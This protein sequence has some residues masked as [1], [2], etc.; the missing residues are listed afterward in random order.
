ML[1]I[2]LYLLLQLCCLCHSKDQAN[3]VRSFLTD[4]VVFYLNGSE[5]FVAVGV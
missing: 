1:S 4:S 2:A 3:T 5:L